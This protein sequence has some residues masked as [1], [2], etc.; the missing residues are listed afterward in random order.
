MII[1]Q[2]NRLPNLIA[3]VALILFWMGQSYSYA[4]TT[5]TYSGTSFSEAVS[6]D[7]AINNASPITITLSEDTFTGIN[8]DDFRAAGKVYF[9]N[10]PAGL[11]GSVIRTSDTTVEVS[12]AGHATAHA[13]ADDTSTVQ[14]VFLDVPFVNSTAQDVTNSTQSLS[15]DFND[16]TLYAYEGFDYSAGVFS[17]GT[18]GSGWSGGWTNLGGASNRFGI[19]ASGLTY[20]SLLTSGRSSYAMQVG[21][22][23]SIRRD[24]TTTIGGNGNIHWFSVLMTKNGNAGDGVCYFGL[25]SGTTAL[26]GAQQTPSS[27]LWSAKTSTGYTASELSGWSKTIAPGTSLVLMKVDCLSG[28]GTTVSI[29]VNPSDYSNEAALG[30]A[31]I[32]ITHTTRNTYDGITCNATTTSLNAVS[33]DEIRMGDSLPAVTPYDPNAPGLL[34][35]S[36][37]MNLMENGGSGAVDVSLI[38]APATDVVIDLTSDATTVATVSPLQMTFTSANWH[39]PQSATIAAV[40]NTLLDNRIANVTL[41]V[42]DAL[43]DTVYDAVSD[44][45]ISV[46]VQNNDVLQVAPETNTASISDGS[47]GSLRFKLLAQ[48]TEDTTVTVS[49][50]AVPQPR[51]TVKVVL[52]GNSYSQG[53]YPEFQAIVG[54]DPSL[55]LIIGNAMNGGKS[56]KQHYDNR[57]SAYYTSGSLDAILDA[58][59]WDFIVFQDLS[60]GPTIY[61]SISDFRQAAKD[62][63]AFVGQEMTNTVNDNPNCKI[64]YYLTPANYPD[65]A[66]ITLSYT[67]EKMQKELRDNYFAAANDSLSA[68]TVIPAGNAFERA[69]TQSGY[70]NLTLHALP[71]TSH[72]NAAGKYLTA[73]VFFMKLYERD[74]VTNTYVPLGLTQEETDYLKSVAAE[75]VKLGSASANNSDFSI[76]G[77]TEFTFTTSNWDQWQT[78]QIAAAS[79]AAG[80]LSSAR[81]CFSGDQ[82][83]LPAQVTLSAAAASTPLE[84]WRQTHFG[85]TDNSGNSANGADPDGDGIANFLEYALGG[86]PMLAQTSI[87]PIVSLSGNEL[88]ISFRRECSEITYVIETSETLVDGSWTPYVTNSGSV[89]STVVV[90]ISSVN[91]RLFVRLRV[92]D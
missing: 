62:M 36:S 54:A 41:S 65:D 77:T 53:F 3:F 76:V 59:V 12:L 87:L 32:T 70:A 81:L 63:T 28:S 35:S 27:S 15:I 67:V 58:E 17:L 75:I 60:Y 7:G 19:N 52:V 71:D 57:L 29:W 50:A 23:L 56:L 10:L 51:T 79:G 72:Q 25:K 11:T 5:L 6:N 49:L 37:A 18:G 31:H 30:D 80:R 90:S 34:L 74:L 44:S 14:L 86:D 20:G 42:N 38:S 33:F 16:S 73:A 66:K 88:S 82:L 55:S 83:T 46:T 85:T 78:V 13:T 40:N 64:M 89:G 39:V 21:A 84:T 91:P 26:C 45:G 9:V 43:S 8:G 48:P 22:N 1:H 2:W 69:Y 47:T 68:G 92:S 4:T 61:G 24:T